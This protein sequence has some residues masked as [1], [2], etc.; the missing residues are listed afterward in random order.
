MPRK[1]G[2]K[3]RQQHSKG[4]KRPRGWHRK[5]DSK[6]MGKAADWLHQNRKAA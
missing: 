2:K 4:L 6:G 5:A 1:N 3:T